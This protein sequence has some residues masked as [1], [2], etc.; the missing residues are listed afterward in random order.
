METRLIRLGP[1]T[2]PLLAALACLSACAAKPTAPGAPALT[3]AH[4]RDWIFVSGDKTEPV[5]LAY[6]LPNSDDI[7]LMLWCRSA[8][9]V[10]GFSPVFGEDAPARRLT[11]Q[12][13]AQT[14][15]A[16]L[17][18]DK[19]FGPSAPVPLG[20]P[21]LMEFRATG[22]LQM[23]LDKKAPVDLNA[24][25]PGRLSIADFFKACR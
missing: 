18:D 9:G 11:L 6:G 24:A 4:D 5:K 7:D 16:D 14:L 12:S 21:L 19:Y 15:A 2:L 3:I 17:K 10:V 22:R 8:R 25:A 23:T 20:A 1:S 13:G